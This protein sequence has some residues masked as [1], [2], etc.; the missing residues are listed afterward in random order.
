MNPL[1]EK[2]AINKN[3]NKIKRRWMSMIKARRI[4]DDDYDRFIKQ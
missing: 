3:K 4:S 1:L 2:Q